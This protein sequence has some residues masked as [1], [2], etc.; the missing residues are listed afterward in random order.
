MNRVELPQAVFEQLND[1]GQ[2]QA[3]EC[4]VNIQGAQ[5][6]LRWMLTTI[7]VQASIRV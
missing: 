5:G 7:Y 4:G 6:R 3:K 1:E 2:P